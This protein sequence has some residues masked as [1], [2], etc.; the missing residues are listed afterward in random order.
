MINRLIYRLTFIV[1]V[2]AIFSSCIAWRF[3]GHGTEGIDDFKTFPTDTVRPADHE[4][5]LFA[6]VEHSVLDTLHLAVYN[7]TPMTLREMI[8]TL[9]R[10]S[11]AGMIVVRRD[12]ILFEHYRGEV[13]PDR[14]S[15]IFSISKSIT[16][17]LVGMAIDKGYI[18]SVEDPVTKYLPELQGRAPEFERL[19]IEHLL[20]MRSGLAF[21]ENYSPNPFSGMARLHYGRDLMGQIRRQKFDE[22]P[23][24]QFEYSSMATA[25]LGA[26][27]EQATDRCF[28]DLLSEWVWQPLG[29]ERYALVNLDDKEHRMAKA[30]GGISTNPR[31]LARW[32][33]L[34]LRN[35]DWEGQQLISEAWIA[36][37][38]SSQRA[39]KNG[40][41][42]N[43]WRSVPN[44][45]VDGE[46]NS[47]TTEELS[48]R[49]LQIHQ[50]LGVPIDRIVATQNKDRRWTLRIAS[51]QFYALGVFGQVVFVDPEK[52]IVA[53]YLGNDR[54]DNFPLLFQQM[55][56]Y[57]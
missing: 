43:S 24:S 34:Y 39:A 38:L 35:G 56:R 7:K 57:L 17:L 52:Q 41:Y 55:A 23:G 50:N 11:S 20:D 30:Y 9:G 1:T 21:R 44:R 33:R 2:A 28:A 31:D 12:T 29:M 49:M 10:K 40:F 8:D 14:H 42:T 18:A 32:G 16:S 4:P 51:E 45:V 6:K 19:T 22:E 3:V 37:S 53:V 46:M 26:V 47:Y 15:T 36:R 25:I 27:L 13:G 54:V 5:F 48:E